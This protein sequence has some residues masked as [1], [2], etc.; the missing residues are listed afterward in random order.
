MIM[1]IYLH[2]A[3][4]SDSELA[5]YIINFLETMD[6]DD[7]DDDLNEKAKEDKIYDALYEFFHDGKK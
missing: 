1:Y 7:L 5:A 2:R 6:S 4:V 3:P